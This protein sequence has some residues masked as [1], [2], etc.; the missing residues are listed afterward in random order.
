MLE[1]ILQEFPPLTEETLPHERR[2]AS[3][4][5]PGMEPVDLTVGGA[6]R[7]MSVRFPALPPNLWR[8]TFLLLTLACV[9]A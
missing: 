4:G 5:F 3:E 8:S 2:M 9:P 1:A 7:S 6:V